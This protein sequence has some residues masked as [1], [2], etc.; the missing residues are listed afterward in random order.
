MTTVAQGELPRDLAVLKTL[1]RHNRI[2]TA[3]LGNFACLGIYA[4]VAVPDGS[5]SATL[6]PC[7]DA[8]QARRPTTASIRVATSASSATSIGSAQTPAL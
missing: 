5:R 8:R 4:E 2:E 3:G 7:S 1:A 6:S